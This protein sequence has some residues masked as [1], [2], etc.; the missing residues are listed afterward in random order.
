MSDGSVLYWLL[1]FSI[2]DFN[3]S[4]SIT[5]KSKGRILI[6]SRQLWSLMAGT[7]I[8][9]CLIGP[10][11]VQGVHIIHG[12]PTEFF[13]SISAVIF[14][15]TELRPD[16]PAPLID[17]INPE[18]IDPTAG[19]E[20]DAIE[21]KILKVLVRRGKVIAPVKLAEVRPPAGV[22]MTAIQEED[23]V[24]V[25]I[26][27]VNGLAKARFVL[28]GQNRSLYQHLVDELNTEP[29]PNPFDKNILRADKRVFG[30]LTEEEANQWIIVEKMQGSV[31]AEQPKTFEQFCNEYRQS[32][33]FILEHRSE[34]LF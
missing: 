7:T 6:A 14:D 10:G 26:S 2:H 15:P 30:T 1:N 11:V 9:S 20:L 19:A 24:R 3:V 31:T 28:G 12:M 16:E 5:A 34:F 29:R 22:P 17:I 13:E 18:V 21:R 25:N 8:R 27:Y 32:I 4:P 23:L 33:D